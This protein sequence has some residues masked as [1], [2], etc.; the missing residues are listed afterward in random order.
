MNK[1]YPEYTYLGDSIKSCKNH[2]KKITEILQKIYESPKG[3]LTGKEIR[4]QV[5]VNKKLL[6]DLITY[7]SEKEKL[8]RVDESTTSELDNCDFD[9]IR[10]TLNKK[11]TNRL[12]EHSERERE[13]STHEI[14]KE[15]VSISKFSLILV[16]LAALAN[17]WILGSEIISIKHQIQI[18][19]PIVVPSFLCPEEINIIREHSNKDI[20]FRIINQGQSPTKYTL[21]VYGDNMSCNLDKRNKK[22]TNT[23]NVSYSIGA[24]FENNINIIIKLP[25]ELPDKF[26]FLIKYNYDK[27]DAKKY[28]SQYPMSTTQNHSVVEC[29]YDNVY[30]KPR[31]ETSK[32]K[33]NDTSSRYFS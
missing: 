28:F 19:Q 5:K 13:I 7:S 15:T 27:Y 32:Y 22:Q 29:V 25:E 1:D 18:T 26:K 12:K 33:L 14:Q 6:H 2:E 11:G 30:K 10:F 8:I 24:T 3:Y 31:Y 4:K 23:C 9:N 17:F 20:I 16:A 21:T